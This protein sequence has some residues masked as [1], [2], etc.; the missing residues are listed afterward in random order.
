MSL[1]SGPDQ[2]EA[3]ETPDLRRLAQDWITLWESELSALAADPE[4]REAWQALASIWS[5]AMTAA[6]QRLP[7]GAAQADH[8]GP[9]S[10]GAGPNDAPRTASAVAAPDARDAEI[11]RLARHVDALERRLAELESGGNRG[12]RGAAPRRGKRKPR[13]AE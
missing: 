9:S 13:T 7:R 6:L 5:G 10:G 3:G 1:E 2:S 4:M 11:E 12:G 8:D